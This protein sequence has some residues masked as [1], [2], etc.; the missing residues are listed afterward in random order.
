MSS[1]WGQASCPKNIELLMP[2]LMQSSAQSDTSNGQQ[3]LC[4]LL[5]VTI[6]LVLVDLQHTL[7]WTK[8][9]LSEDCEQS[10]AFCNTGTLPKTW[11]EYIWRGWF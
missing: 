9:Q 2:Q 11:C 6:D 5:N 3:M 10:S 8:I 1:Q 7:N 4:L